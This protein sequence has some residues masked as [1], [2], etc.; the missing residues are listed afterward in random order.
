MT[1]VQH[2]H[3][4][5]EEKRL[6]EGA[7][8]LAEAEKCLKTSLMKWKADYDSAAQYFSKAATC[9][10]NAKSYEQAKQ[11]HM[12]A[13]DCHQQCGAIFHAGKSLEQ[14]ALVCR[15]LK[16][17][18]VAADLGER[19]AQNFRE[20]GVPDTAAMTLDKIA[21][22]VEIYTPHRAVQLYLKAAE[23]VEEQDRSRQS[24]GYYGKAARLLIR[25]QQLEEALKVISKELQAHLTIDALTNVHKLV[26]VKVLIYLTLGDYVAADRECR[27]GAETFPGFIE[28]EEAVATE[29]LL[30]A[31]DQGDKDAAKVILN[32]PKFKYL[33]NEYAKLARSLTVP[34]TGCG[35]GTTLAEERRQRLAAKD[36]VDEDD[37]DE[38]ADGLC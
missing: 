18:D 38:Y 28:S 5:M 1:F 22:V 16:E 32:G 36:A 7:A 15:D 9:F 26:C 11:C 33:D 25:Q 20:S 17:F 21:K 12:K 8:N 23:V 27:K 24:I 6:K 10:K 30:E 3:L 35:A 19:A 2:H 14:A 13:A 4:T 34:E 31:Y 29:L 37:D